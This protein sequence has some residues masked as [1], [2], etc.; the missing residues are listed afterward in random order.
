MCVHTCVN[1]DL[2]S[3]SFIFVQ[4]SKQWCFSSLPLSTVPHTNKDSTQL[5]CES[6][7]CRIYSY[8]SSHSNFSHSQT[9]KNWLRCSY[10]SS[11]HNVILYCFIFFF[12]L[13][14]LVF[15]VGFMHACVIIHTNRTSQA[16]Q[17]SL[18]WLKWKDMNA[19]I[20]WK[21]Y[22]FLVVLS[23]SASLFQNYP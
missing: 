15:Y 5:P 10:C 12:L 3:S 18:F 6:T 14:H 9:T 2:F 1:F 13:Y 11:A 16:R 8:Y 23:A 22:F 19:R 21:I 4:F 17:F 20:E 7:L